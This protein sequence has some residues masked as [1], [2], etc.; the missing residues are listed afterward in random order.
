MSARGKLAKVAGLVACGSLLWPVSVPVFGVDMFCGPAG[1]VVVQLVR[2]TTADPL[3][4][5]GTSACASRA[6]P[7]IATGLGIGAT[8]TL[9]GLS[10]WRSSRRR[11]QLRAPS[12]RVPRRPQA[13]PRLPATPVPADAVAARMSALRRQPPN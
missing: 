2:P 6:Y 10:G 5:L 8:G 4:R 13:S 11:R 1:Y 12:Q 7:V 9:L 3:D